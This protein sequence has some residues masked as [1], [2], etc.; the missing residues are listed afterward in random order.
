MKSKIQ[1]HP[2]NPLQ[3]GTKSKIFKGFTLL[4]L[5]VVMTIIGL[6]MAIGFPLFGSV[7]KS[8]RFEGAARNIR[9]RIVLARTRSITQAR[10]FSVRATL[11]KHKRWKIVIV[12]SVDNEFDNGN[13]RI[14]EDPLFLPKQ[15]TL[16]EEMEI[17]FMPGVGGIEYATSNPI[18]LTEVS[19]K[20]EIWKLPLT[21]YKAAG[22]ARIGELEKIFPEKVKSNEED[23][24][25][26]DDDLE[27][28][29]ELEKEAGNK[30]E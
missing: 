14:V 9:D 6:M 8:A 30:S 29:R 23:D 17:E 20:R 12:D 4:E 22:A 15:V 19:D 7:G 2:P 24:E 13:D 11:T 3:R 21:L 1:Q 26:V 5:L 25:I 16:D 28:E 10:K 18:V 27:L